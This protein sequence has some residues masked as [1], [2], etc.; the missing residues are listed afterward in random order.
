[1]MGENNA[2]IFQR[3]GKIEQTLAR[4][5]ERTKSHG[6]HEERIRTLERESDRHKGVIAAVGFFGSTIGA[7]LMWLFKHIFGGGS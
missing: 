7:G 3:L 2:E 5:D 6:D 1:M 4:I